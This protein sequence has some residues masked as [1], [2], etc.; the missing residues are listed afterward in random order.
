MLLFQVTNDIFTKEDSEFLIKNGALP[1]E[2]ICVVETGGCTHA[3]ILEDMNINLGPLE[4][5]SKLFK[6]DI[7]L[8]ESGGGKL[9]LHM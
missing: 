5:L 8:C 2:R 3:A 1:E 4:E 9:L 6:K 7:L